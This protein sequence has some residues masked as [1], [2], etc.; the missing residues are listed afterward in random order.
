MAHFMPNRSI[1]GSRDMCTGKSLIVSRQ[2]ELLVIVSYQDCTYAVLSVVK[3]GLHTVTISSD[4]PF[5]ISPGN[6]HRVGSDSLTM[7]YMRDM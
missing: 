6:T 2:D 5:F 1:S 3:R 4:E 7:R